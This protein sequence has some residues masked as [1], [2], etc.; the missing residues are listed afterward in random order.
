MVKYSRRRPRFTYSS[1]FAALVAATP[2]LC[3]ISN[4][5]A[6]ANGLLLCETSDNDNTT[7]CLH[8]SPISPQPGLRMHAAA[9]QTPSSLRA[10]P[11]TTAPH[12]SILPPPSRRRSPVHPPSVRALHNSQRHAVVTPTSAASGLDFRRQPS[13]FCLHLHCPDKVRQNL[14]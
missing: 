1:R 11:P 4:R 12:R 5:S 7:H 2:P 10:K 3:E 8:L 6:S 13:H 14:G 9:R